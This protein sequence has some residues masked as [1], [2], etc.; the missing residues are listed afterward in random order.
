MKGSYNDP[1]FY[2]LNTSTKYIGQQSRLEGRNSSQVLPCYEE[3][4]LN[5]TAIFQ[6]HLHMADFN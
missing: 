6:R 3:G 1:L 2:S 5:Y 4:M